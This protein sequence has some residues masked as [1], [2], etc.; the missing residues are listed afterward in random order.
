MASLPPLPDDLLTNPRGG[1]LDPRGFFAQP[2]RPLEIEIGCGKGT[3]LLEQAAAA[4]EVNFLAFEWERSIFVYAADRIRRRGLSNVRMLHA[5]AGSFLRWR[6]PDGCCRVIHLY[7]SDPWPKTKHHKNRVIQHEFLAQAW[8]VLA[9]G[10]GPAS[11]GGELRVVTDHDELWAWDEAHF[12]EWT[13]PARSANPACVPEW[14]RA[15]LAPE[16]SPFVREPFTPPPW[17]GEGELVGTNYERKMVPEGQRAHAA[18]LRRMG[19][20]TAATPSPVTPT[21]GCG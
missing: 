21:A 15:Q 12:A 16:G 18:T 10:A 17:V 5:D 19:G 4:P 13:Q 20:P 9:A 8:R 7:F 2:D 11:P 1:W 14:I 6:L 3:F